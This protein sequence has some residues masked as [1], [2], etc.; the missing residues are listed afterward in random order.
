MNLKLHSDIKQRGKVFLDS[1]I[2]LIQVLIVSSLL[3]ILRTVETNDRESE[4]EKQ[5]VIQCALILLS[6]FVHH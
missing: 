4:K 2:I 5:W 6:V 1:V 3:Y